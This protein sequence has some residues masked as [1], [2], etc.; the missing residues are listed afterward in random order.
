MNSGGASG[1]SVASAAVTSR[2]KALNSSWSQTLKISVPPGTSTRR[3]SAKAR[4]LSGKNITPNWQATMSKLASANG[5]AMAS[6][7][8]QCTGR[9][10]PACSAR[11]SIGALRSVATIRVSAGSRP[12]IS[13]VS[14]P[15]PAAS[16]ST[17]RGC[18]AAMRA[19]MSAAYGAKIIGTIK[20]S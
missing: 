9:L 19:A 8:R 17:R 11:A 1:N 6:A 15:V 18:S 13:R 10:V 14:T 3:A 12:A 2:A 16:S 5:S 7:S 20:A 4:P